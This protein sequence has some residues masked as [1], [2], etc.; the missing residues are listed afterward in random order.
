MGRI[1][2]LT[3]LA[4]LLAGEAFAQGSGTVVVIPQGPTNPT[5]VEGT[6]N[7][8]ASRLSDR[9]TLESLDQNELGRGGI[10]CDPAT[11]PAGCPTASANFNN[12]YESG[13]YSVAAPGTVARE[14]KGQPLVNE[15]MDSLTSAG[16]VA[17]VTAKLTEP[18]VGEGL[19]QGIA[20]GTQITGIN[21]AHQ[22][23]ANDNFERVNAGSGGEVYSSALNNCIQSLLAGNAGT[24]PNGNTG[25][26]GGV[27]GIPGSTTGGTTGNTAPTTG[28]AAGWLA[29][30]RIC[31]AD[32]LAGTG[33]SL[34]TLGSHPSH[35]NVLGI[36]GVVPPAHPNGISLSE[37]MFNPAIAST[38]GTQRTALVD[39][40]RSY[41]ERA[42]DILYISIPNGGKINTTTVRVP[43]AQSYGLN[44]D[45]MTTEVFD[46]LTELTRLQCRER[47]TLLSGV[48]TTS[49]AT[50]GSS[51]CSN[52]TNTEYL[53][54]AGW[55]SLGTEQSC[56]S[57][58][59]IRDGSLSVAKADLTELMR[60]VQTPLY[61]F[62][63]EDADLLFKIFE[64][65]QGGV[66]FHHGR[67]RTIE[68]VC[69]DPL[70]WAE[71][72]NSLAANQRSPHLICML[73]RGDFRGGT[74]D[75]SRSDDRKLPNYIVEFF[76]VAVGIAKSK[77][78]LTMGLMEEKIRSSLRGLRQDSSVV[79]QGIAL[80]NAA[81]GSSYQSRIIAE[82]TTTAEGIK[83]DV[84]K[85]HRERAA[86]EGQSASGMVDTFRANDKI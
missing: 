71:V 75:T 78:L 44:L 65:D 57:Y 31:E 42:G 18:S 2:T 38:T 72:H 3:L 12:T 41:K 54:S 50:A 10:E 47:Y 15:M 82:A 85:A 8:A 16:V 40:S 70:A 67:G 55:H 29:A 43:P 39:L 33:G 25:N 84:D 49:A 73:K 52:T 22:M 35:A 51:G 63:P 34:F 58:L 17:V 14:A 20:L 86:E 6:V 66:A 24:N 53:D 4:L 68:E 77:A 83:T 21:Y 1:K 28:V 79:E 32:F 26:T 62:K 11:D 74:C 59:F 46:S 23:L 81:I 76:N 64:A 27:G 5:A 7:A 45:D 60:K 13:A 61:K 69:D 9:G 48:A 37:L 19:V 56:A 36:S 30:K 80:L